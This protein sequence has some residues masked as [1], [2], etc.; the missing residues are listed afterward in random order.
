MITF[1]D[2]LSSESFPEFLI[3]FLRP[4]SDPIGGEIHLFAVES[5]ALRRRKNGEA[6]KSGTFARLQIGDGFQREE[7]GEK[8]L[9]CLFN[10]QYGIGAIEYLSGVDFNGFFN[11]IPL[12]E[13]ID[14]SPNKV[15][16]AFSQ[17][18]SMFA[19]RINDVDGEYFMLLDLTKC[20]ML[21][22][23]FDNSGGGAEVSYRKQRKKA[24]PTGTERQQQRQLDDK[25]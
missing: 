18:N 19:L 2:N 23:Q 15:G 1:L 10:M 9:V 20:R 24:A 25:M 4:H 7:K 17:M 16:D 6:V 21:D 14:G 8:E 11:I 12:L 13:E 22:R 3:P 5:S